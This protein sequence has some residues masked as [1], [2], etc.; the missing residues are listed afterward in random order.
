M[1]VLTQLTNIDSRIN[2]PDQRLTQ[3]IEKWATSLSNYYMNFTKP[4]LDLVLFSQKLAAYVSWKGPFYA[5]VTYMTFSWI[6]RYLSPAFGRM[7][8][9]EQSTLQLT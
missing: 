6:L 5:I 9:I 7:R 3:D 2:N 4:V 8:A 1:H